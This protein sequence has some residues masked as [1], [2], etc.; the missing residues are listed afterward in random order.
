MGFFSKIFKGVKKVFKKIG[1][2]IKKVFKKN[3]LKILKKSD[4]SLIFAKATEIVNDSKKK[5]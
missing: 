1:R 3:K 4:R 2:G 5:Y